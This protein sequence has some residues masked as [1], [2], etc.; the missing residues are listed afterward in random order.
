M[1]SHP[2]LKTYMAGVL[3]PCWLLLVG[4]VLFVVSRTVFDRPD[5]PLEQ[6]LVY[7]VAVVPNLWG[8]WNVLYLALALDRRIPLGLWGALLP[9]VLVP[10]ALFLE[11]ALGVSLFSTREALTV[12]PIAIA[13]YY[14]VWK[15]VVGFFNKVVGVR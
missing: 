11:R 14:L 13:L 3:L 15:H 10:G 7:P 1:N 4:L 12:L 9:L 2:Y 5:Y 8:L 6:V